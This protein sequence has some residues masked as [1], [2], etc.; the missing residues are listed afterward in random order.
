VKGYIDM[1]A[2]LRMQQTRFIRQLVTDQGARL[3]NGLMCRR[4]TPSRRPGHIRTHYVNAMTACR[5]PLPLPLEAAPV[6][7]LEENHF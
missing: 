6:N 7:K 4:V 3:H 1:F 2:A 5:L